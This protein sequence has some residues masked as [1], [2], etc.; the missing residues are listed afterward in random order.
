MSKRNSKKKA[1]PKY[2]DLVGIA[3]FD[4]AGGWGG[5]S[6]ATIPARLEERR[7]V[8]YRKKLGVKYLVTARVIEEDGDLKD[9]DTYISSAIASITVIRKRKKG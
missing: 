7:F 2:G 4:H 8:E 5:L 6:G 9:W 3:Y 1:K